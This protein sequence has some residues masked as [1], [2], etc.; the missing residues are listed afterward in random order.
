[1]THK[2]DTYSKCGQIVNCGTVPRELFNVQRMEL[3]S[4]ISALPFVAN[5]RDFGSKTGPLMRSHQD[6][7]QVLCHVDSV[8]W[9]V[10]CFTADL[11]PKRYY[12]YLSCFQE[13]RT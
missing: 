11:A 9:T 10:L 13:R 6:K 3:R 2:I 8:Q 5:G 1:M 7:A 12:I 4:G